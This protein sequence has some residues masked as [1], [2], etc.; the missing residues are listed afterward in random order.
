MDLGKKNLNEKHEL[1]NCVIRHITSQ[2]HGL[3]LNKYSGENS[4]SLSTKQNNQ[5]I[6]K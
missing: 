1:Q 6:N 4:H 5:S 2:I 3:H